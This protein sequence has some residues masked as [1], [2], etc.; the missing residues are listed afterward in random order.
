M[1]MHR[2]RG[3]SQNGTLCEA[4]VVDER[5]TVKVPDYLSHEEAATLPCA[6]VTAWNALTYGRP[7]LP[8]ES[9][10]IQGTGGVSVFALQFAAMMGAR[11]IV[12]SSSDEKLER[13]RALGAS[14]LVNYRTTPEW[15]QE[16]RRSC[17]KA[18]TASSRSAV[19]TPSRARSSACAWAA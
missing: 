18:S 2:A 6:G 15:H 5:A 1:Q 17:R 12:T 19:P 4:L 9:V 3:A 11:V 16:V 13:A 14:E 10:L 7:T 8:G